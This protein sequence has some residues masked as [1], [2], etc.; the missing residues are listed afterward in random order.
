MSKIFH[1]L[2]EQ[3]LL[4]RRENIEAR[5]QTILLGSVSP[6]LKWRVSQR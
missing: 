2:T 6:R 5:A 3:L 4:E 1:E